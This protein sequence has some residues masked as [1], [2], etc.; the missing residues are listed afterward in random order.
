MNRTTYK[1][2]RHFALDQ[3]FPKASN[4]IFRKADAQRFAPK[5]RLWSEIATTPLFAA[6]RQAS[7]AV[8]WA[9]IVGAAA[10]L[11]ALAGLL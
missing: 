4:D 6:T 1:S 11:C 3:R 8:G 10:G 9:V 5:R 7:F 2:E